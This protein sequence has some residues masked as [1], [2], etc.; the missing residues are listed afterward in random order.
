[1]PTLTTL[2]ARVALDL[3]R[4]DLTA[5]IANA[6]TDAVALYQGSRFVFNQARDTFVTVAGTEFYE[7]GTD[8][9]D[10]PTDVME[11]DALSIAV[12]GTRYVLDKR[13]FAYGEWIN[14]TTTSRGRPLSWSWYAQ[15]I[16]LY[17]IPDAA[18]TVTIS[19]LQKIDIP[20]SDGSS[21]VWTTEA[22]TLIRAAAVRIICRDVTGHYRKAE[23]AGEAEMRA[24]ARLKRE[25]K[26]LESGYLLPSG[27]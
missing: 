16:R 23:A 9:E 20:A 12:N 10:I 27:I 14:S 21:N 24:L 13:G 22:E 15:K 6:I 2:K 19:Y 4:T 25:A 1:M 11:V 8:P 17:P 5:D 3:R 26:Q 18:Y 7:A